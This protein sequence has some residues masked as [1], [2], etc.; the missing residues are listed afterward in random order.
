MPE[1]ARPDKPDR[2]ERQPGEKSIRFKRRAERREFVRLGRE[3]RKVRVT[4]VSDEMRKILKHPRKGG[5]RS[6]GSVEWPLD[7]FTK[8]RIRDGDVTVEERAQNPKGGSDAG[9]GN[10]PSGRQ[11]TTA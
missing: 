6:S 7:S 4:P 11:P 10:K 3:P 2:P 1:Q 9:E 8:R 5:F